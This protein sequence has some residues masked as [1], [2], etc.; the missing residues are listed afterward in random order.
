[1]VMAI[2]FKEFFVNYI[3]SKKRMEFIERIL[4]LIEDG[5]APYEALGVMRDDPE[6]KSGKNAAMYSKIMIRMHKGKSFGDAL[7]GIIP[8][9]ERVFI[10]LNEK[11]GKLEQG[12]KQ[13][14]VSLEN[15][16]KMKGIVRSAGMKP[17]LILSASVGIVGL[18]HT[19][20]FPV[21]AASFPPEEWPDLPKNV[22]FSATWFFNNI[23]TIA[24]SIGA[25]IGGLIYVIPRWHSSFREK[26]IDRIPPFSFYGDLQATGAVM[27]LSAL[28][29]GGKPLKNALVEIK[30]FSN[31]REKYY[32]NMIL[33]RLKHGFSNGA[34]LALP[35]F[36][37]KTRSELRI[38]A[39]RS[40]FEAAMIKIARRSM[41]E[42]L[43]EIQATAQI[44]T[45][46]AMGIGASVIMLMMISLYTI[47]ESFAK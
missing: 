15:T 45:V 41:D 3:S 21:L 6:I 7:K 17:A 43:K 39:D 20:I 37:A 36:P 9:K 35:L 19:S 11:N 26:Y 13:A 44:I 10:S 4:A 12:I 1:M 2:N 22:Y 30:R 34:A 24:G 46:L 40:S 33:M 16:A 8:D 28:V 31:P 25:V 5:L 23:F 27:I 29:G 14:I 18:F 47:S 42:T 32:I 38:F